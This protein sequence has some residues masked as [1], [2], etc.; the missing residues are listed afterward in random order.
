MDGTDF[1]GVGH[2]TA[3]RLELHHASDAVD[4]GGDEGADVAVVDDCCWVVGVLGQEL[5]S[6]GTGAIND[7]VG[8]SGQWQWWTWS[9]LKR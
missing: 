8:K 4:V 9:Q 6:E 1:G 5:H 2:P 7:V 3:R